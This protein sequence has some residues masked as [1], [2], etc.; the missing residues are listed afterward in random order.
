MTLRFWWFAQRRASA[1]IFSMAE[2]LGR[3]K[4]AAIILLGLLGGMTL[5]CNLVNTNHQTRIRPAAYYWNSWRKM[6]LSVLSSSLGTCFHSV[7][8][9]QWNCI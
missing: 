5:K 4:R 2:S 9:S 8:K 1:I 7:K 6:P 3:E